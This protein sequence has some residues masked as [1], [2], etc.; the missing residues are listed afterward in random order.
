MFI[1][2]WSTNL[3]QGD[4]GW[5]YLTPLQYAA[6]WSDVNHFFQRTTLNPNDP[7]YDPNDQSTWPETWRDQYNQGPVGID[8]TV[9]PGSSQVPPEL[10]IGDVIQYDWKDPKTGTW[11][12][13]FDH[14]AIVVDFEGGI[15]YVAA[16]TTDYDRAPYTLAPDAH[17]RFIHIERSNG[18]YPVKAQAQAGADDAGPNPLI[19][20]NYSIGYPELYL[21]NCANGSGIS[22]GLRFNNVY[23]PPGAQIKYAYLTFTADGPYANAVNLQITGEA[24]PNAAASY[25]CNW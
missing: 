16:H 23:I 13:E 9:S 3:G 4:N 2:P 25:P 18:Y 21:G 19:A 1:S 24:S 14:T 8:I 12:G 6:G 5:F 7:A 10:E 17:Y 11:D 15:P 20:C 22:S